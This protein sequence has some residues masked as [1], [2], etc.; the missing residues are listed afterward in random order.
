MKL[1]KWI[2]LWGQVAILAGSLLYVFTDNNANPLI[3]YFTVGGWQVLSLAIHSFFTESWLS[4]NA[5]RSY[6]L[7]ILWTAIIGIVSWLTLYLEWSLLLVYLF[8]LLAISPPFAI[9][10]FTICLK[11]WRSIKNKELIHLK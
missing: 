9:W 7:T 4:T 3:P 1:F 2:D 6:G 11:E 5:R 10:Y 8:A